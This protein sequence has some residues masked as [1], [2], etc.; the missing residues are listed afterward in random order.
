LVCAPS[1]RDSS[2][3]SYLSTLHMTYRLIPHTAI[4]VQMYNIIF[5]SWV[6]SIAT[7]SSS[8]SLLPPF[9]PFLLSSPGME[10][11]AIRIRDWKRTDSPSHPYPNQTESEAREE[12]GGE[13]GLCLWSNYGEKK[14][15]HLNSHFRPIERTARWELTGRDRHDILWFVVSGM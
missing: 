6:P 15:D 13:I 12:K 9:Q 10:W 3:K 11:N 5:C 2:S 8:H 7:M 4:S 14:R 1:M